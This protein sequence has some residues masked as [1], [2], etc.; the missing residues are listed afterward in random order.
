MAGGRL[1]KDKLKF[2]A[3]CI[4]KHN[5]DRVHLT[6]CQTI[7]LHN[8]HPA[9]IYDIVESALDHGIVTRGGGGDFPRNVMVSPLSGVEKGNILMCCPMRRRQGNTC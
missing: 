9:A 3:D 2:V 5:I 4:A 7:Q 6:T 1:T 8:L